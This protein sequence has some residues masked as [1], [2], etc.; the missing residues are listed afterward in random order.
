VMCGE[1]AF[2][3]LAGTDAQVAIDAR[4]PHGRAVVTLS[5]P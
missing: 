5:A 1:D 3:A 2:A 4:D